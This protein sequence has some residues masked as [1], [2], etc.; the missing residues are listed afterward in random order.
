MRV[1]KPKTL[2]TIENKYSRKI[3]KLL[4]RYKDRTIEEF[5]MEAD[6]LKA[7]MKEELAEIGITE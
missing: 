5:W 4:E 7:K 6:K 2:Q 1:K 3:A